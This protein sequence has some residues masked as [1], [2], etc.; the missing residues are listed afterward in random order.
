MTLQM[1]SLLSMG[2]LCFNTALYAGTEGSLPTFSGAWGGVGGGYINTVMNGKTNVSMISPTP[3][4]AAFLLNANGDNKIAPMVN[5]G[6]FLDLPDQWLLGV[7]GAYKY[8]GVEQYDQSWSGTYQNGTYQ[9]AGLHT[10]LNQDFFLLLNSGYQFGH[11]LV[12]GGVG[13]SITD[14]SEQLNGDM[15]LPTSV[16]F[17]PTNITNNKVIWGG[18]GQVGF[19]YMLP[20]RFMVDLSYNLV[21]SGNTK[22]P[23]LYFLTG[24]SNLY[25]SFAQKV[26]VVEQGINITVNKY[27]M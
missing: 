5:A 20:H 8:I 17:Q 18:A 1:K 13:P 14:V 12:Y 2:F 16:V 25:T 23:N 4:S 21:A 22:I 7:K 27:F 15:L 9:T 24:T 11:W 3:S 19:E 6:Y 26:Q 10:K